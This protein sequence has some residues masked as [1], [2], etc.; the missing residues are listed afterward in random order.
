MK[1]S[2]ITRHKWNEWNKGWMKRNKHFSLYPS[3]WYFYFNFL[4]QEKYKWDEWTEKWNDMRW[5]EWKN[6]RNG[7]DLK[8]LQKLNKLITMTL[9]NRQRSP[10]ALMV[11]LKLAGQLVCFAD[12][13]FT[14]LCDD[15]YVLC[16]QRNLACQTK[17]QTT[18][19]MRNDF[20]FRVNTVADKFISTQF[21]ETLNCLKLLGSKWKKYWTSKNAFTNKKFLLSHYLVQKTNREHRHKIV[22]TGD[23]SRAQPTDVILLYHH[24]A[25]VP[26]QF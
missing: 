4:F 12:G 6:V 20:L 24:H 13:F 11:T 25:E 26:A 1:L 23:G 22:K 8:C 5:G 9:Y 16:W 2:V 19:A 3:R 15:G 21:N 18:I 7:A 10:T 14:Y 17:Q